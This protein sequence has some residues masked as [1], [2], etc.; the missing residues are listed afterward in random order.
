[1]SVETRRE[2]PR[3][4]ADAAGPFFFPN[5][6]AKLFGVL[7][8]PAPSSRRDAGFVFCYPSFE[9]KLWVHRVFV[10]LADEFAAR[11]YRVLRFDYMGHGDSD[12]EFEQTSITT[13]LSDVRCAVARLRQELGP[14]G[15]VGLLGLRF[16]GL[17]AALHAIADPK[18]ERLILWDPV[19]D[20]ARYMQEVLLANLATQA[21]GQ[22]EILSTRE[23][24]VAQMAAG[25][26][27]N[28]EG[29]ELPYSLY[30]EA[31]AVRL[32]ERGSFTNPCL[33]V[34]IARGNQPLKPN[35]VALRDSYSNAE[36]VACIE[37][38][39]W[40]EIKTFYPRAPRLFEATLTWL[41]SH[42]C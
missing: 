23:D 1:M 16:G 41:D 8:R 22:R 30:E 33:I 34:Q 38:P 18:V 17:L 29:Y 26:T 25:R 24:L 27:V 12:G 39:F 35:L 4:D 2:P 13:Q 31:S 7:H 40:K 28:I 21:V 37:E 10:S 19:T 20:G 6:T 42:G 15:Q 32:Q 11:G 9:E 5:D 14:Q 3:T 36:L